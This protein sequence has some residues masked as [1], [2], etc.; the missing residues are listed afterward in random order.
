M[1][2]LYAL[3]S[4]GLPSSQ[5]PLVVCS[6]NKRRKKKTMKKEHDADSGGSAGSNNNNNSDSNSNNN[7]LKLDNH[8]VWLQLCRLKESNIKSYGKKWKNY[9]IHHAQIIECPNHADILSGRMSLA[10]LQEMITLYDFEMINILYSV[11]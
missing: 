3:Q 9:D 7:N 1:E 5:I 8:I 6:T 2:C 10:V 4:F 11:R